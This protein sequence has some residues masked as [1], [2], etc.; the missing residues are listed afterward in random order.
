MNQSIVIRPASNARQPRFE[1]GEILLVEIASRFL[2][3][4]HCKDFFFKRATA[5]KLVGYLYQEVEADFFLNGSPVVDGQPPQVSR[6]PAVRF[7]FVFEEPF[8]PG[9]VFD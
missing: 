9:C 6:V 3:Q 1:H 2:E 7:N 4:E 8:H 5:E